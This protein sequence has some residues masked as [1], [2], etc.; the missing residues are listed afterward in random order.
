MVQPERMEFFSKLP[1]GAEPADCLAPIL[2]RP[3]NETGLDK[4][5]RD[6]QR[7]SFLS[8]DGQTPL[9][10]GS[11]D[12]NAQLR[13]LG[14]QLKNALQNLRWKC[15]PVFLGKAAEMGRSRT[16]RNW[17]RVEV[18]RRWFRTVPESLQ[19][20]DDPE[21]VRESVQEAGM[22]VH[23]LGGGDTSAIEAIEMSAEVCTGPTI[24]YQPF[25]ADL[26]ADERLWLDDFER[27]LK[28]PPGHYQR[29]AGKNDQEL[30]ALIDEQITRFRNG[31]SAAQGKAVL[32]LVCDEADLNGVRQLKDDIS[33]RSPFALELPDFLGAP[34]KAMERLR[35][36]QDYFS[37]GEV[38]LF[39]YGA[40]ERNRLELIWQ[41]AESSRP[42]A[43]RG[44]FLAPP[45]L[46]EKLRK[47]PDALSTIDQV[48]RFVEGVR[49]AR[50]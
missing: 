35:K 25:G 30:V 10:A 21:A 23:F 32:A 2:I 38:L 22:A 5:Y 13:K 6:A 31:A 47:Q 1:Y 44:W 36:W 17:C 26:S 20:L 14:G 34:L 27:R 39:Y 15:R 16:L 50:V 7:L 49:S 40:A 41:K 24:L 45:D 43:K 33:S 12:W 28:A 48:I 11:P 37:R 46:A 29:L 8:A 9:A 4:L 19:A 18:E 3:V 42:G